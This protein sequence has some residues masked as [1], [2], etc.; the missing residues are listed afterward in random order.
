MIQE[1]MRIHELIQLEEDVYNIEYLGFSM[2][3]VETVYRS[4]IIGPYEEF[5]TLIYIGGYPH[6]INC[7]Y[8]WF[9][10]KYTEFI[11]FTHIKI[12]FGNITLN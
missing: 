7:K 12:G 9:W 5:E 10:K 11:N 1:T 2:Y 6:I 4:N 8:E 3:D